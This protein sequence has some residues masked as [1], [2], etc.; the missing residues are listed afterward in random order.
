MKLNERHLQNPQVQEIAKETKLTITDLP[1][2]LSWIELSWAN[3]R[4]HSSCLL[5]SKGEWQFSKQR[6]SNV[7]PGQVEQWEGPEAAHTW[8][9]VKE[10]QLFAAFR[11]TL[12][13]PGPTQ[14]NLHNQRFFPGRR[15]QIHN[16][17]L[18]RLNHRRPQDMR[19]NL[20]TKPTDNFSKMW[21]GLI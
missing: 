13:G 3:S 4:F 21:V 1:F 20:K 11:N 19:L 18:P 9:L 16:W 15:I 5:A 8:V 12:C 17:Q 10:V 7:G 2:E 14:S 6:P